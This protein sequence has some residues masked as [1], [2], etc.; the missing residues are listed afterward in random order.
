MRPLPTLLG[1]TL[2]TLA[3]NACAATPPERPSTTDTRSKPVAPQQTDR[4]KD[5]KG[6]EPRGNTPPG[7]DRTGGGPASGAIL[8]PTGAVT[9]S[10][11]PEGLAPGR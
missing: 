7:T 9:K 8:D 3:L 6:G 11:P 5:T 10:A 2:L 1:T 4:E